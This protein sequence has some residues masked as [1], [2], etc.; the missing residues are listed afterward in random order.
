MVTLIIALYL[1]P[2]IVAIFRGRDNVVE[3]STINFFFG[4]TMLGWLIALD[5]A[6]DTLDH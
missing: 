2:T 4:W 3:I 1:F 6:F 5:I